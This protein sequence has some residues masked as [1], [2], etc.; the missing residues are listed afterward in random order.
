M[1]LNFFILSH[2]AIDKNWFIVYFSFQQTVYFLSMDGITVWRK[3]LREWFFDWLIA[4]CRMCCHNEG[5]LFECNRL[6]SSELIIA[7]NCNRYTGVSICRIQFR[8]L[9]RIESRKMR[10][11]NLR[12]SREILNMKTIT[13]PNLMI[14][15]KLYVWEKL[16]L[17]FQN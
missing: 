2:P 14:W 5:C 13:T 6:F 3:R 16:C 4:S 12:V 17:T 9:L 8:K 10:T 1:C 7:N 15:E 11:S